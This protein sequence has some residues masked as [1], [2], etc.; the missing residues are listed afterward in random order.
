MITSLEAR[1]I[2]DIFNIF[3]CLSLLLSIGRSLWHTS[4]RPLNRIQR[5][6]LVAGIAAFAAD[7][8]SSVTRS[9]AGGTISTV[10]M[11][12]SVLAIYYIFAMVPRYYSEYIRLQ[13]AIPDTYSVLAIRTAAVG[14][15]I[16]IVDLALHL[17]EQTEGILAAERVCRMLG[18][19]PGF[20]IEILLLVLLCR[21]RDVL[22]GREKRVIVFYLLFPTAAYL[23]WLIHPPVD[24]F[25]TL[26]TVALVFAYGEINIKSNLMLQEQAARDRTL[27][28]EARLKPEEV[29]EELDR[30]S[31]LCL[32]DPEAARDAL[33]EFSTHLR[34][35]IKGL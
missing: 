3:V 21:Y 1:P 11:C 20:V 12:I 24:L 16:W 17:Q 26:L 10:C 5:R 2:L 18:Q 29:T 27:A 6:I 33:D 28:L 13:T 22:T 32:E 35:K 31:R 19:V 9:L 15:L 25:N 14:S 30:I 34:E 7:I 8:V 4:L 23:L